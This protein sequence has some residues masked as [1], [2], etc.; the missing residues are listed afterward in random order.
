M[1]GGDAVLAEE[2]NGDVAIVRTG[3]LRIDDTQCG[4]EAV[5]RLR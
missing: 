2:D 3:G 5:T 4:S 1:L